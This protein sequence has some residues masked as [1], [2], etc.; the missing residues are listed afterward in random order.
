MRLDSFPA[1][2]FDGWDTVGGFQQLRPRHW[3][4]WTSKAAERPVLWSV[5]VSRSGRVRVRALPKP[6]PDAGWDL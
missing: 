5:T 2:L 1:R 6:D 3:R 4:V